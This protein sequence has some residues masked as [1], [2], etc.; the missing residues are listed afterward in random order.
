MKCLYRRFFSQA[1]SL[2]VFAVLFSSAPLIWISQPS[3]AA[4]VWDAEAGTHWWFDPVNWNV[5]SNSNIVL[6]PSGNATGTSVTDA[7]INI[8]SGPWDLGDGV[9]YDPANDPYF[10]AAASL[11]YPTGSSAQAFAGT[12]YGPQHLFRLFIGRNV[13]DGSTSKLTIK[14]GDLVI[15]ST[16]VVGRSGSTSGNENLG[17]IVQ[18]GGRLRTPIVSMDIGQAETSGWGNGTYDYRGGTL[19]VDLEGVNGIRLAHGGGNALAG[20]KGKFVVHNPTSGG[21]VRTWRYQSASW[22]GSIDAILTPADPDG[23]TTGVATTEFH[24]ENGGTRPFQ[25]G[26]SLTINNGFQS[27]TQGTVSSRLALVL[28][29]APC[30]GVGC[31]PI[32]M[33]LFDIDFDL[34]FGSNGGMITGTGSLGKHFSGVDGISQYTEGSLISAFFGGTRYSWTISYTGNIDWLDADNSVVS[35]ITGPGTGKDVVLLG[36]SS[37]HLVPEPG[38]FMLCCVSLLPLLTRRHYR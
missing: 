30:A 18:M 19:E 17:M 12:D 6:P 13:I 11:P 10:P 16:V 9:V 33:G 25:I 3:D 26:Q 27:D 37:V 4:I 38:T 5:S 31:V 23:F 14:G 1:I 36:H 20:G 34:G 7:Q 24:Y 15:A 2:R 8:G 29:E 35:L 32:N 28:H 22:R 21:H